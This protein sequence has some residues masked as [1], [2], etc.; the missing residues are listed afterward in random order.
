MKHMTRLNAMETNPGTRILAI[1]DE[2]LSSTRKEN[3][4]RSR[5]SIDNSILRRQIC[6][7]WL[8]SV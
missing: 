8:K 3:A 5:L 7:A 4:I 6:L 1:R 2:V